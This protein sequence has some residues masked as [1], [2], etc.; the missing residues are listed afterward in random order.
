MTDTIGGQKR[1]RWV[2][3]DYLRFFAQIAI[4]WYHFDLSLEANGNYSF[5]AHGMPYVNANIH[6]G[7]ISVALF[8]M[9]S[10]S[11]LM[12]KRGK[13]Q[14]SVGRFYY[15]R[16]TK[17]LIPFYVA[18]L[19]V[20]FFD[21]A[22]ATDT[23]KIKLQNAPLRNLIFTALGIDG[24]I[25]LYKIPTFYLMGE[26]FLGALILMYALFPLFRWIMGKHRH[27]FMLC[28]TAWLI[29][30]IRFYVSP[31]DPWLNFKIKVFDF[32][33]GM[34]LMMEADWIMKHRWIGLICLPVVLFYWKS[35]VAV[36]IHTC[37]NT[38]I[39]EAA[40]FVLGLSLESWLRKARHL[41]KL[42]ELL[43]RNLFGTFLVHHIVIFNLGAIAGNTPISSRKCFVMFLVFLLISFSL[44]SAVMYFGR[45]FAG[46]LD[47]LVAFCKEKRAGIE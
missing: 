41:N 7:I 27:I 42:F 6:I 23:L 20:A 10:G 17:I 1:E 15:K 24:Y 47:R 45:T 33:L 19:M 26:W 36:P 3:M 2:F 29:L 37:L 9:L 43:N 28:A 44:G 21:Y 31:I 32:I 22:F 25:S 30:N 35:P 16:F 40:I 5:T 13:N 46:W 11:G 12:I 34:Y 38:A 8:F 18:Y 14:D 39:L 4:F